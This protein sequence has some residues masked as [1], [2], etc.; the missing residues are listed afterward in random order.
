MTALII[1]FISGIFFSLGLSISGMINPHVVKGFLNLFGQWNYSLIFV[2]GGAVTFNF[3]SFK[4][5]S[6]KKPLC[7]NE[8][9]WPTNKDVDSKLIVGS[10]LFG[11][12]WGLVGICPGP[13][14]VNLIKLDA[15]IIV[16]VISM[17]AGMLVHQKWTSR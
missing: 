13:A 10:A 7:A 4:V 11:I 3:I 5:I 16:F 1:S 9:F 14:I 6:N 12:G 15:K 8:H 17:I 2:M